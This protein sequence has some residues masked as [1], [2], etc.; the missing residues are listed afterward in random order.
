MAHSVYCLYIPTDLCRC[1]NYV[2]IVAAT[3][4]ETVSASEPA[5][6]GR[7]VVYTDHG[8][9]NIV[10]IWNALYVPSSCIGLRL[11]S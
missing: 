6:L 2:D 7:S 3:H 11:Q 9:N 8:L 10:I 1:C 5:A 4:V